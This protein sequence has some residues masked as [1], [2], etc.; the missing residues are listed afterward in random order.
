MRSTYGK[1][2]LI[3]C[4]LVSDLTAL[5]MRRNFR[6]GLYDPSP[7]N[8]ESRQP[9]TRTWLP[10]GVA[11]F[12]LETKSFL[13]KLGVPDMIN[14]AISLASGEIDFYKHAWPS[15]NW[16]TRDV[17]FQERSIPPPQYP[18][19]NGC[20]VFGPFIRGKFRLAAE[21]RIISDSNPTEQKRPAD[22]WSYNFLRSFGLF[23]V[24][25]WLKK[26]GK[27]IS[28]KWPDVSSDFVCNRLKEMPENGTREGIE[29]RNEILDI[30][31]D[32]VS[33]CLNAFDGSSLQSG[34]DMEK[35]LSSKILP[36][37]T[38]GLAF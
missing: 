9:I 28:S 6:F 32:A 33:V 14:I 23:L 31:I 5:G 10:L 13:G 1:R 7:M 19:M 3:S 2:D 11:V 34:I 4:R 37:L 22:L 24:E 36:M 35:L 21:K 15:G 20:E 8:T 25:L 17:F 29:G 16:R 38:R 26:L 30:W 12:S 27:E 18:M